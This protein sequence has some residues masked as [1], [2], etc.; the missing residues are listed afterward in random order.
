[1]SNIIKREF[2]A[3]LY[4]FNL[5]GWSNATEAAKRFNKEAF[6]CACQQRKAI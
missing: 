1:M 6:E 5:E 3:Q 2:K 4:S